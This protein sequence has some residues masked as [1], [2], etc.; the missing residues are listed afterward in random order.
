MLDRD[1]GMKELLSADYLRRLELD[2]IGIAQQS[3]HECLLA[4]CIR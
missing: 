3:F 2:Y 1:H 4:T